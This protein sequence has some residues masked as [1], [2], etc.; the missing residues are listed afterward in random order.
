MTGG[1]TTDDPT[2][3]AHAWKNRV[4]QPLD[5][6]ARLSTS[7]WVPVSR[8]RSSEV[9]ERERRRVADPVATASSTGQSEIMLIYGIALGPT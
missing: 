3:R 9:S 7:T 6:S 8:M 5:G 2:R 4:E 1:T